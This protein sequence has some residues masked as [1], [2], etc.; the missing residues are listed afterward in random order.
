MKN[1]NIIITSIVCCIIIFITII[2]GFK[3]SAPI[4]AKQIFNSSVKGI[5]E[6]K[7]YSKDVG[8]SYGTAVFLKKTELLYQMHM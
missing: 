3:H 8:E 4:T 2:A 6:L 7:A 5:V 1:K